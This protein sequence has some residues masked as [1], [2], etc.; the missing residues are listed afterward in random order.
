[1]D[2]SKR[3]RFSPPG[4]NP[5]RFYYTCGDY[6]IKEDSNRE[7]GEQEATMMRVA[8]YLGFRAMPLVKESGNTLRHTHYIVME[9]LPGETLEAQTFNGGTVRHVVSGLYAIAKKLVSCSIVHGDIN[10]SNVVYHN[11]TVKL[12]D[13]EMARPMEPGQE[14]YDMVAAPWGIAKTINMLKV[15]W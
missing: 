7:R 6:F 15:N 5:D 1:M 10:V 9:K 12:I 4:G 8:W 3:V 14:L 2:L 11:G 13:W